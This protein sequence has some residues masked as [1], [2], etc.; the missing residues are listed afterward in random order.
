MKKS[1]KEDPNRHKN[2][3]KM[4]ESVIDCIYINNW[5]TIIV[6]GSYHMHIGISLSIH[7]YR[8]VSYRIVSHHPTKHRF[9]NASIS[10][11]ESYQ[12]VTYSH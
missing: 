7:L 9:T 8:I 12:Y 4:E 10:Y 5:T 2:N 6:Y 11:I 3:G 1:L